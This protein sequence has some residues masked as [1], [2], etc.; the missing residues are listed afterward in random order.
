[1]PTVEFERERKVEVG[2]SGRLG[3]KGK[4]GAHDLYEV[5]GLLVHDP[6]H[7]RAQKAP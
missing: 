6:A 1:M 2:R 5:T 3:L 7:M 4:S